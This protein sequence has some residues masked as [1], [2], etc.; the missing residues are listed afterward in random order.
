[1]VGGVGGVEGHRP[2]VQLPR[3]SANI[4]WL[5]LDLK[6]FDRHFEIIACFIDLSYGKLSDKKLINFSI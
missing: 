6:I 5:I 1:M 3:T 4:K 2:E